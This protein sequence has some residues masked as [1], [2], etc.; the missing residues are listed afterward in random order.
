MCVKLQQ[1]FSAT[2]LPA[3]L[4][5]WVSSKHV[6]TPSFLLADWVEEQVT[7]Q[8]SHGASEAL[9]Q[10]GLFTSMNY[11]G[12]EA[13]EAAKSD[14]LMRGRGQAQDTLSCPRLGY[15]LL[16][17]GTPE[18]LRSAR[19]ARTST[20]THTRAFQPPHL[21]RPLYDNQPI[22]CLIIIIIICLHLE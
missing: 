21:L 12:A 6:L 7:A 16:S 20:H 2:A 19:R 22:P 3:C 1:S 11:P 4:L 8:F 5:R 14:L 17:T 18:P 10:D 13:G 9:G 15:R